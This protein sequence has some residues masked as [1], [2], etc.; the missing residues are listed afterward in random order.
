M[1]QPRFAPIPIE[2][3]VRP[4]SRLGPAAP[5]RPLRPGELVATRLGDPHP[6]AV[7]RKGRGA[8][9]P[10]QGYALR[11]AARFADRVVLGPGERVE[12]AM[13]GAVAVAMRRA[14]LFG[15]APVAG[16]LEVALTLLGCLE[17]AEG[18]AQAARRARLAGLGH[19][20]W[21]RR[22]LAN[23]IPDDLLRAT[24]AEAAGRRL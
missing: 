19:D 24:P 22:E 9:G 10:D 5:W 20:E 7:L 1:T 13:A 17:P 6:Q 8:P 11:L 4:Q 12:D 15:R 21:R 14:S 18:A 2:D 23:S 16:D 3:E